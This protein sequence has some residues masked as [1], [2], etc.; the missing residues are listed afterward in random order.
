MCKYLK[1]SSCHSWCISEAAGKWE[2]LQMLADCIVGSNC[3]LPFSLYSIYI[4]FLAIPFSRGE[5]SFSHLILWVWPFDLLQPMVCGKQ[6]CLFMGTILKR[7]TMYFVPCSFPDVPASP[8]RDAALSQ[9]PGKKDTQR[10]EPKTD[11]Q[12][13][14]TMSRNSALVVES[15]GIWNVNVVF[16]ATQPSKS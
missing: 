1:F 12:K 14:N 4:G 2:L 7:C 11:P 16:T 3:W 6:P 15:T 5:V 9:I 13:E 8:G 10:Q